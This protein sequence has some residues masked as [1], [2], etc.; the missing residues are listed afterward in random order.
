M[1]VPVLSVEPGLPGSSPAVVMN[2]LIIMI[3]SII[4]LLGA[5]S[6]AGKSF[7]MCF[8]N[9]FSVKNAC[10]VVE[11]MRKLMKQQQCFAAVAEASSFY[12]SISQIFLVAWQWLELRT[13]PC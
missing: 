5:G 6:H 12:L 8:P 2:K 4:C 3:P 10:V 7:R 13:L 9:S 11:R 1:D